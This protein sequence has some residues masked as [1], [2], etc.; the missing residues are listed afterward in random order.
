MMKPC[1]YS[2][3]DAT[4]QMPYVFLA[5]IEPLRAPNKRTKDSMSLRSHI[6]RSQ[7]RL[8]IKGVAHCGHAFLHMPEPQRNICGDKLDEMAITGSNP[9]SSSTGK[10]GRRL[11]ACVSIVMA[12]HT[13]GDGHTLGESIQDLM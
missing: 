1:S 12:L 8:Y 13:R 5:F 6:T 7:K 9:A 4:H 10:P 2:K 11:V 3:L